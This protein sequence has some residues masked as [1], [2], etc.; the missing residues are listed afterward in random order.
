MLKARSKRTISI[1]LLSA[2]V[3][4]LLSSCENPFM[5]QILEYK[6]VSFNTNGGSPVPAQN[7][8]KGWKITQP[9]D[10]QKAGADF[11][12][13]YLDNFSFEDEWDF[14]DIPAAD[15][16]L[17]ARWIEEYKITFAAVTVTAPVTDQKPDTAAEPDTAKGEVNFSVGDV[18]WLP[19]HNVFRYST[20]YT[21]SVTLTANGGYSFTS[22]LTSAKIN[23]YEAVVSD[24]TG[25]T[26]TLSF[27]FEATEAKDISVSK[28]TVI[29][30]PRFEYHEED[31]LDLSALAVQIDFVGGISYNPVL[32]EEFDSMGI[33]TSP[34]HG[35]PLNLSHNNTP[36]TVTLGGY[37]VGIGN[38]TVFSNDYYTV[39]FVLNNE[40][41]DETRQVLNGNTIRTIQIDDPV[42]EADAYLH[43]GTQITAPGFKFTGWYT[44]SAFS[45]T[46]EWSASTPVT[47]NITLFAKYEGAIDLSGDTTGTNDVEKAI[48][49]VNNQSGT[50]TLFVCK[51]VNIAPQ[52]LS[53]A[54][55]NL[56]IQG[57]GGN[58]TIQYSGAAGSSLFTIGVISTTISNISLILGNNI[59]LQ[60]IAGATTSLVQVNNGTLVMNAGSK[61][62][63]HTNSNEGGGVYI[64]NGGTF[65]MNGGEISENKASSGGGVY[66]AG[67]TFTMIDGEVSNNTALSGGGVNVGDGGEFNM[68]GNA[69][70][71]GNTVGGDGGG[72]FVRGSANG[73]TI[74]GTFNMSGNAMLSGNTATGDGG[75][76]Y[77][78]NF[79]S[80]NMNGGEI[81]GGNSAS[82]GGGVYLYGGNFIVSNGIVYGIDEGANS[83]TATIEGAALHNVGGDAY[84]TENPNLMLPNS[85][86][87]IKVEN[88]VWQQ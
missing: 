51:N 65:T 59:T 50:Y 25:D 87:T 47:S 55:L 42:K 67:G 85:E 6:T 23:K 83:N 76:V 29:T 49:Y 9:D 41:G 77:I 46:K 21:A 86:I 43:H 71:L 2:A 1:F 66:V 19:D 12:G 54:N 10:P 44:D 69:K 33:T 34:A 75:G 79:G 11:G 37:T 31:T 26:V 48:A 58:K 52:T 8:I 81:G 13:W 38:L 39:T 60:G 7:L 63:S 70:V 20:R 40:E 88:G 27:T 74:P 64:G 15:M 84:G 56:T 45:E 32:F 62:T 80:F 3:C 18:S 4:L 36:V 53:A 30:Q 5:Q 68:S 57:Y 73:D 14:D 61:I 22:P 28:I 16:I 17:H 72:V 24:N 82:N 35:Q 78:L